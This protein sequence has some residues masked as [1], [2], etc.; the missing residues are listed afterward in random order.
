MCLVVAVRCSESDDD[1][2]ALV[3]AAGVWDVPCNRHIIQVPWLLHL[4][5]ELQTQLMIGFILL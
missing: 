5:E 1:P 4:V 3:W 2:P